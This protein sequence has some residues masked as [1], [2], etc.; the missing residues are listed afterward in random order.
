MRAE[1]RPTI[2]RRSAAGSMR[3]SSS[4]W[5]PDSRSRAN[6][7]TSSGV[8]VDPPPMT[9]IFTWSSLHSGQSDTLHERALG[10]EEHDDDGSHGQ[11]GGRGDQVPVDVVDTVERRQ[12][13]RQ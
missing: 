12:T 6:P 1:N 7:S 5:R 9:A 11:H 3:T 10:E 8:Y 2:S 13:Q 4:T